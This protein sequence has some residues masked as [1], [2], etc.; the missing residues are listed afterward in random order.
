MCVGGDWEGGHPEWMKMVQ[1]D[2]KAKQNKL[3]SSI[4]KK[5][6]QMETIMLRDISQ[7]QKQ[8][9]SHVLIISFLKFMKKL[10][11]QIKKVKLSNKWKKKDKRR[12][13]STET[14]WSEVSINM[15]V[16]QN[17]K[18]WKKCTELSTQL[19]YQNCLMKI[20][21]LHRPVKM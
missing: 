5:W 19:I 11:F 9:L 2:K 7:S 3:Y 18:I 17:W 14:E 8:Q 20:Q 4:C 15:Y 10:V 21:N 12:W 13:K 1:E 16:P 6:S